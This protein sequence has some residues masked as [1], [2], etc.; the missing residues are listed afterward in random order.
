M[1]YRLYDVQCSL[2]L[3]V[4]EVISFENVLHYSLSLET[5][6]SCSPFR[7]CKTRGV[8]LLTTYYTLIFTM[9]IMSC[10]CYACV[11]SINALP[12]YTV[13]PTII[14]SLD[15][16]VAELL[17]YFSWNLCSSTLTSYWILV[18]SLAI[19]YVFCKLNAFQC[20]LI[21]FFK[22]TRKNIYILNIFEKR[23]CRWTHNSTWYYLKTFI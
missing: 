3:K 8:G 6:V 22:Y 7:W 20:E 14:D 9:T 19:I 16:N 11:I 5:K 12:S 10:W 2:Y 21:F 23:N 4:Y 18:V 17:A 1:P 13:C 15:I